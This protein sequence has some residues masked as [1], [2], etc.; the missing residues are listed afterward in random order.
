MRKRERGTY[1]YTLSH[2][3]SSYFFLCSYDVLFAGGEK[4]LLT[5]FKRLKAEVVFSA[6][7]NSSDPNLAVSI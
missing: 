4:Q 2:F 1:A 5:A 7:Y 6:Q 3:I